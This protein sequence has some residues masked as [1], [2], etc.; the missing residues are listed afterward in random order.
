M[1]AVTRGGQGRWHLAAA[2]GARAG[3]KLGLPTA[4]MGLLGRVIAAPPA[5]DF[6]KP[7]G[8]PFRLEPMRAVCRE[9]ADAYNWHIDEN[10][11][12]HVES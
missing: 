6:T 7:V 5:P 4:V 12:R 1:K 10:Y 3:L 9:G 2:A 8:A 11:R